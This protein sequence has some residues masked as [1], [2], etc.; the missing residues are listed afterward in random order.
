MLIGIKNDRAVL[1][2]DVGALPVERGRI[3]NLPK[4]VE[5]LLERHARWIV[6]DL[7]RLR[8]VRSCRR[9]PF[10]SWASEPCRPRI[11]RPHRRRLRLRERPTRRPRN[12]PRQK[13]Q[14]CVCW[15]F[16]Y[17]TMTRC[18]NQSSASLCDAAKLCHY[19]SD[20]TSIMASLRS[21]AERFFSWQVQFI[22]RRWLSVGHAGAA[23][24]KVAAAS[25][26]TFAFKDVA[27]RFEQQTG[28]QRQAQL[29]FIG[30]FFRADSKRR[31]VRSFLFR[32][33]RLS[34]EARGR[35]PDRARHY[36]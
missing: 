2:A 15:S 19:S 34:A 10:D 7:A 12:I 25:D 18:A 16:A 11:R 29:R 22:L 28:D 1:R 32:R 31:A 33:R 9:K 13:P 27:A 17:L 30:E 4:H 14:V 23:E 20:M 5:Q 35:R 3:V 6:L 36:L 8:R 24:I 21:A 26:L